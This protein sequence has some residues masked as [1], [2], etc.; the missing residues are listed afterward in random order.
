MTKRL[1]VRVR[2]LAKGDPVPLVHVIPGGDLRIRLAEYFRVGGLSLQGDDVLPPEEALEH[3]HAPPNFG[4]VRIGAKSNKA[5]HSTD[6][7][8]TER[9]RN[10]KTRTVSSR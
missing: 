9:T 10:A 7:D 2:A 3:K 4:H 1:L 5:Q 8:R 6:S